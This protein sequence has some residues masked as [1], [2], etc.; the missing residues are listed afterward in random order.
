MLS[1]AHHAGWDRLTE[2]EASCPHCL[3]ALQGCHVAEPLSASA[4]RQKV[5]LL[6]RILAND[7]EIR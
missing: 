4:K 1:A 7:R 5:E 3:Q 6:S 2:L